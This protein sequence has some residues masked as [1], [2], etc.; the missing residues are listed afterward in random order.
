VDG[1]KVVGTILEQTKGDKI[2]V[3]KF[4]RRKMYRRKRGHRQL[5]TKVRIE[6]IEGAGEPEAK[7]E[8][9]QKS[10]STPKKSAEGTRSPEKVKKESTT[11]ESKKE[12]VKTESKKEK[13]KAESK[14]EESKPKP[15]AAPKKEKAEKQQEE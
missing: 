2:T 13:V 4:K 5:L 6:S 11:T 12:K 9:E 1:A 3:F 10:Q 15:K 8:N 14:K 7:P